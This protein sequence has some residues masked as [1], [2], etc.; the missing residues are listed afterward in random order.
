MICTR[1]KKD[2]NDIWIKVKL[3]T[4]VERVKEDDII[5]VVENSKISSTET[6][7]PECFEKFCDVIENGMQNV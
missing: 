5:E 7:C 2:L 4:L 1:C 3:D 6:L